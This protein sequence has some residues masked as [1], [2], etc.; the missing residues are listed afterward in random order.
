MVITEALILSIIAIPLGVI[1]GA[2]INNAAIITVNSL[3]YEELSFMSGGSS[4]N[5]RFLISLPIIILCA[6]MSIIIVVFSAWLPARKAAKVSVVEAVKLT[7]EVKIKTRIAK[8]KVKK[9][10]KIEW[11]YAGNSIKRDRRKY[12]VT[13]F[14]LIVSIVIVIGAFSFSENMSAMIKAR[15]NVTSIQIPNVQISLMGAK[16]DVFETVVN[17][18]S[19][20]TG[21]FAVLITIVNYDSNPSLFYLLP[22]EEYNKLYSNGL[23]VNDDGGI[24]LDSHNLPEYIIPVFPDSALFAVPQDLFYRHAGENSPLIATLTVLDMSVNEITAKAGNILTVL[25]EQSIMYEI[26]ENKPD[27]AERLITIFVTSFAVIQSFTAI[28]IVIVTLSS[29]ISLRRREFAT[30]RSVGMTQKELL[31]VLDCESLL[32]GLKILTIGIP[33]GILVSWFLYLDLARTYSFN[34]IFPLKSI[35]ICSLVVSLLIFCVTR[36]SMRKNANSSIVDTIKLEVL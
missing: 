34:Y 5:L 28:I 18:L 12:R 29:G 6:A 7:S 25:D 36:I 20:L 14:S 33:I 2:M 10:S 9:S 27:P 16:S 1:M 31:R 4:D 11:L 35:F 19:V 21:T 17:E 23:P 15:G 22:E 13:I 24:L 26:R 30:M 8:N 32:Y 3:F